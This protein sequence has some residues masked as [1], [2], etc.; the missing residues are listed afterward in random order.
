MQ[1]L[2]REYC[3]VCSDH[4]NRI[5]AD[6]ALERIYEKE[7][8][9]SLCNSK[10]TVGDLKLVAHTLHHNGVLKSLDIRDNPTCTHSGEDLSGIIEVA[11]ALELNSI[12]ESLCLSGCSIGD[13]GIKVFVERLWDVQHHSLSSLRL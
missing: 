12:L 1:L 10:L 8:L 2:D 3:L 5:D 13:E 7:L 11:C 4:T 6:K 9:L